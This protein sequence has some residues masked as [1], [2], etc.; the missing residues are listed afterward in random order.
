MTAAD[1]RFQTPYGT[2]ELHRY[3]TRRLEPLQAWSAADSLLLE[4][5]HERALPGASTLVVNDEQGA[6]CVAVQPGALWTDSALSSRAL[7]RNQ[8]HNQQH[9]TPL[10]WST[11]ALPFAPRQVVLRIPKQLPYFAYQLSHLAARMPTG[12]SVLAAGMDKHLSPRTAQLLEHYIGPTQRLR[13]QRK[14]RLFCATRDQRKAPGA[15][16]TAAYY[17]E[18]LQARLCALPNVFSREK[19]DPGSRFLLEQ[20]AVLEPVETLIDLACGNGVLGLAAFKCGL[21]RNVVFADESA[22]ALASAS[23]NAQRI[24]PQDEARCS[25]HHGDGLLDYEGGPVGLIL[26]NPPFHL[27]HTVDDYAGRHLLEQ[28]GRFL[29][30]GGRLCL[31]ANRHLDYLPTLKRGFHSVKKI[32]LN[33]KFIVWLATRP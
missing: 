14:A 23:S 16:P 30:P 4:Q 33:S 7:Q 10:V 27:N 3:P 28:C 32:A 11:E 2:F 12:A 1:T 17:C 24:V 22:M 21:T 29:H 31:V 5:N 20:L 6:L 13:G 26:C 19:L 15:D 9:P 25:F 18:A 8:E